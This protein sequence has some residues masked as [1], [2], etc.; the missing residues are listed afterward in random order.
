[1]SGQHVHAKVAKHV[2]IV[3]YVFL[4]QPTWVT[5]LMVMSYYSILL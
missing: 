1:M 2:F 4:L 3:F 5:W